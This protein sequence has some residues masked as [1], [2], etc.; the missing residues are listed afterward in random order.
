[1]KGKNI[2]LFITIFTIL[3]CGSCTF[4][5]DKAKIENSLK[6]YLENMSNTAG[7]GWG[8]EII[9]LS[10]RI[11]K[12]I[13]FATAI[14]KIGPRELSETNT[15]NFLLKKYEKQGWIVESMK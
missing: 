11:E 7:L 12:N 10:I 6:N 15:C 5:S 8:F 1:M 2:F 4:K 14:L 9:D 3:L 13:A